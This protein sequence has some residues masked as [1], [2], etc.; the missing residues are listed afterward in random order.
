MNCDMCDTFRDGI[1]DTPT[2]PCPDCGRVVQNVGQFPARVAIIRG[3]WVRKE[4]DYT[5]VMF[6]ISNRD[7]E[8]S[9]DRMA[10]L[11]A[12]RGLD[13]F[14]A[15]LILTAVEDAKEYYPLCPAL[16]MRECVVHEQSAEPETVYKVA[17][18]EGA[19]AVLTIP[20]G[21]T[22]VVPYEGLMQVDHAEAF[23]LLRRDRETPEEYEDDEEEY[24]END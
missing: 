15:R 6:D 24:G 18:Y 7:R 20:D 16:P 9:Q 17:R 3:G 23:L 14:G 2:I 4:F 5:P 8:I 12:E 1:P 13:E 22:C 10:K 21:S 11:M 19:N